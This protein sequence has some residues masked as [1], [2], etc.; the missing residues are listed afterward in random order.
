LT[1]HVF[2]KV[3]QSQ[4]EKETKI[5]TIIIQ[6]NAYTRYSLTVC[7]WHYQRT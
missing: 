3:I 5:G 4:N 6:H 7:L 2:D 1:T